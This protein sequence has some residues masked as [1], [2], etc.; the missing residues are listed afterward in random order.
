MDKRNTRGRRSKE[1]TTSITTNI[2][3][4]VAPRGEECLDA[5]HDRGM[6]AVGV[7][8]RDLLQYLSGLVLFYL[9]K[10]D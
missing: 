4:T 9:Y 2:G 8:R 1:N 6:R 7:Q 10:Y 3:S 5:R